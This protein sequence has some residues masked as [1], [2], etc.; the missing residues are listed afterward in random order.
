MEGFLKIQMSI[1]KIKPLNIRFVSL[2]QLTQTFTLLSVFHLRLDFIYNTNVTF[3]VGSF[4][5]DQHYWIKSW[6]YQYTDTSKYPLW[7]SYG[8]LASKSLNSNGQCPREGRGVCGEYLYL[9]VRWYQ[10]YCQ[11]ARTELISF[12]PT[13]P[14]KLSWVPCPGSGPC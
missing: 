1:V 6:W 3:L 14:R 2:K 13:S 10:E 12:K 5:I 8:S 7:Y 4:P 9:R 11:A